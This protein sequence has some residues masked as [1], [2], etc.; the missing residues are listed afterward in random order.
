MK[1]NLGSLLFFLL[2]NTAHASSLCTYYFE[3]SNTNPFVKE[4]VTIT[5]SASQKDKSAVM[6]YE[7][8]PVKG[9][10]FELYFLKKEED[11]SIYHDKKV[12]YSYL[13]YPLKEGELTLKFDFKVSL[14]SDKSMEE[15]A[16]GNR[17][18]IKP[19]MTDETMIALEPLLF[20]VKKVPVNSKLYGDY[21]LSM[22]TSDKNI[23]THESVNVTYTI[24]GEGYPSTLQMILPKSQGVEQFL[25]VQDM[26][27]GKQ[28]FHY[29]FSSDKDFTIPSVELLAFSTLKNEAYKLKTA[30]IMIKVKQPIAK[31]ILDEKN[32]LPDAAFDWNNLLPYL[33]ALLLFLAGFVV[34]KLNLLERFRKKQTTLNP[35]HQKIKASK[36]EKTLLKL[37][38]SENDPRF[39]PY[40]IAL[41]KAIYHD[42]RTSLKTIKDALLTL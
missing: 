8:S 12:R 42:K 22:Q 9:A 5:F 24:Q 34:A 18:V 25:E 29:V 19:M 17:D 36:D 26:K 39:S 15:F 31:D 30:P 1:K 6:F 40:I 28:V 7:L 11:K 27:N 38:L 33:N 14:A 23:H 10:N 16:S 41:E 3:V 2:I 32:S 35:F 37:L 20:Q 21:T 13:L 4:G